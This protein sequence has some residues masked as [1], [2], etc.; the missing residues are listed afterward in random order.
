MDSSVHRYFFWKMVEHYAITKQFRVLSLQATQA[1]FEDDEAKP[2]RVIRLVQTEVDWANRLKR[3]MTHAKQQFDAIY[4]QLGVWEL[5][6]DNIYVMSY[7]PVDSWEEA[8]EPFQ[9]R[10][11]GTV[12][13]IAL[14][15]DAATYNQIANDRLSNDNIPPFVA[16]S[17]E[18]HME[19]EIE[20]IRTKVQKMN[21]GRQKQD[22]KTL[23]FGKPRMIYAILIA[24][25]AM[26]LV[27]ELNG[28]STNIQILID[29]G[30]KY[31][32]L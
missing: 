6:G 16:I 9:V 12:T 10:K 1:W 30:A 17:D 2:R 21:A 29:Y 4:K 19:R 15:T 24:I 20:S 18:G 7:P 25:I 31:N 13:N 3:D 27:L 14:H 32:P 28:G 5:Q 8:M 26:F 23:F 22:E 11:K